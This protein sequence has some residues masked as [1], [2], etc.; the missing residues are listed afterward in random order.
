MSFRDRH[1]AALIQALRHIADELSTP[2]LTAWPRVPPHR[3]K[4]LRLP[5]PRLV[6]RAALP[7]AAAMLS[8]PAVAFALQRPHGLTPADLVCL[9]TCLFGLGYATRAYLH[10]CAGV[11]ARHRAMLQQRALHSH[12]SAT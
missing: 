9:L 1:L 5:T 11:L 6:T 7:A 4:A 2:T 8:P 3:K 10:F 12:P